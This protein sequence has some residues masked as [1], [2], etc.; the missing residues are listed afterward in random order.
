VQ[1]LA[2]FVDAFKRMGC[3]MQ[4]LLTIIGIVGLGVILL[5]V[6]S[7]MG[8]NLLAGLFGQAAPQ[9][10]ASPTN[11]PVLTAAPTAGSTAAPT[12]AATSAPVGNMP[13][14]VN[15]RTEPVD[16]EPGAFIVY[17]DYPVEGDVAPESFDIEVNGALY[18]ESSYEGTDF[19]Y[20]WF[21]GDQPCSATLEVKVVAVADAL[22]GPSDPV[23]VATGDC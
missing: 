20:S 15:L 4:T 1:L 2:T 6:T 3:A 12:A 16:G 22:R 5:F 17:W 9:P 7:L 13:A 11:T 10:S 19:E 21:V 14:P 8:M 18:E 23:Q